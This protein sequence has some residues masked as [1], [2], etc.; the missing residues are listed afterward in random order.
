MIAGIWSRVLDIDKVGVRDN[1]FDLG[2]DSLRAA[3]L[4][5]RLQ[6][7][8]G[9]L[10]YVPMVFRAPTVRRR[11]GRRRRYRLVSSMA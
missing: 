4:V 7:E 6:Q 5:N 1:F 11:S 10:V 8:L 3:R 9:E 2:G